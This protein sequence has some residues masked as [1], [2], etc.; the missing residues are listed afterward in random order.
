[1]LCG[2]VLSNFYKINK[3]SMGRKLKLGTYRKNDER[4]RQS[5]KINKIGRPRKIRW[6]ELTQENMHTYQVLV[7]TD[8]H[9]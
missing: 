3:H 4:K 9:E 8:M 5:Q 7:I 1:M 6:L 2:F